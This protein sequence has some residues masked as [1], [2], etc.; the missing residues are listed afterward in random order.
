[1]IAQTR[2]ERSGATHH[3]KN[4]RIPTARAHRNEN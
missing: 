3:A 4:I 2:N 1:M